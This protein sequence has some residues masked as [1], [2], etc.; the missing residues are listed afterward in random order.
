[1]LTILGEQAGECVGR[2]D[3]AVNTVSSLT[4]A[5]AAEALSFSSGKNERA[6]Q[7]IRESAASVILCHHITANSLGEMP[8]DKTL[9]A[10]DNP[11]LAFIQLFR[12]H[13]ANVTA[14]ARTAKSAR[15]APTTRIDK[16][17]SIGEMTVI[18]E[19]CRVGADTCI[20]ASVV[21]YEN[22]IVG[23][24]CVIQAGAVIG[25]AGYGFERDENGQLHRF[26]QMG[27]VVIDDDVE[28]GA[29]T[30]IDRAALGETRIGCGTKIDDGAY[31]AH[32]VSV[33]RD[34]LIMAQTIVCGSSVI[35]DRVEVSPG[36]VIRD[37]LHVGDDAR[38]GLGAVVVKDVP[39]GETVAGVPA[40]SFPNTRIQT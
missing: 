30:S 5:D 37:K 25:A 8:G 31:I 36:A 33:G 15:I 11:R 12:H 27:R 38:I 34:C 7:E 32:N 3:R 13:A 6:I 29:R 19:N 35:G 10:V 24:R 21:L 1:M 26:P 16:R 23:E 14:E 40:R 17:V 20:D 28:I 9:I 2:E 22:T 4:D 39:R 18:G